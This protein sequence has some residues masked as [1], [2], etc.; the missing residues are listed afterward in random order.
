MHLVKVVK[1]QLQ[2]VRDNGCDYLLDDASTF[3]VKH[4]IEVPN[5]DDMFMNRG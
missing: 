4:G 1:R 2:S 3:C 5:M